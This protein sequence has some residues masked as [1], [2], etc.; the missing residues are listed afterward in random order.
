MELGEAIA[1]RECAGLVDGVRR[2]A[3]GRISALAAQLDGTIDT[4]TLVPGKMLRTRFAAAVQPPLSAVQP[5]L[6]REGDWS[7][8]EIACAATELV[9]TASLCHDD[10]IDNALM[11]RAGPTL[12]RTTSASGAVLIGDLLLCEATG[13]LL[14]LEGGAY[15]RAFV[16]KVREMCAAEARQELTRGREK[17]PEAECLR[18]ARAKTGALFAFLGRVCGGE[19]ETLRSALEEA[20]Y[21]VGTAYQLADDLLDVFGSEEVAAKTLGTDARRR[22]FTLASAADERVVRGHI[23]RLCGSALERLGPW[24]W[25]RSGLERFFT[26][27]LRP[28][29][30]RFGGGLDQCL[31]VQ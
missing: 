4:V 26:V 24:P 1:A 9:H 25:A 2:L 15:V 6:G 14:E 23:T 20:G 16:S 10:V 8:L 5:P 3:A 28:V 11:R 27:D 29:F 12:W 31:G 21:R 7:V 13:L 17:P 22:K 18:L 19:E 30:E